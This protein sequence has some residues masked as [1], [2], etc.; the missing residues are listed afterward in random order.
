MS[1][2][3]ILAITVVVLGIVYAI[4]AIQHNDDNH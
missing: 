2:F 3:M 4:S 1:P